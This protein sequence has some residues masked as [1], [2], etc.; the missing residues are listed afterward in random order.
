M[1]DRAWLSWERSVQQQESGGRWHA[2]HIVCSW[3]HGTSQ[4]KIIKVG[5]HERSK[6]QALTFTNFEILLYMVLT[7]WAF[8]MNLTFKKWPMLMEPQDSSTLQ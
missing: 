3:F 8:Y 1:K 4:N 7:P 6:S 5:D 2:S